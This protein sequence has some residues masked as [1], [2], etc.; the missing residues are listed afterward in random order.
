LRAVEEYNAINWVLK[1]RGL[2][3]LED[4]GIVEALA[5]QVEDHLHFT[6]L[7]RACDPQLR[8]EMY[9]GMR[10]Y[11]RFPAA[12]LEEYVIAAKEHAAAAGLPVMA[13]D[14]ALLPYSMPHITT[15]TLTV[16]LFAVCS[17]CNTAEATFQG[18]RYADAI[19][20]MRHAGWA[21]NELD[22]SSI[23]PECLDKASQDTAAG[24]SPGEP[25]R[26]T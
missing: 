25:G 19:Q 6:E 26:I 16:E 17:R 7:L 2:G 24:G 3:S 12:P 23:C 10:P 1:A 4:P 8:R 18:D 21:W 11:L 20:Q 14:G 13:P 15:G 22:Q 9:E 5:R